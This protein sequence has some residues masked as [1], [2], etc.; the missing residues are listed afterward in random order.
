MMSHPTN[1]LG[2]QP[3]TKRTRGRPERDVQNTVLEA[4]ALGGWRV[5]HFRT[6]MT[7]SGQYITPVAADGKGF[8]D[9][10][11]VRDRVMAI[12]CKS[13]TGR[14]SPEQKEWKAAFENAG[15]EALVCRPDNL[16]EV[17]DELVARD[18]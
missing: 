1:C 8:P 14:M 15:V 4:A 6:A 17:C 16:Q 12:E 18:E 9:L 7:R 10:L 11:L 13:A 5:A 2:G 3:M